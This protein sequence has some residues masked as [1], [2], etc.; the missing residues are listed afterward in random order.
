MSLIHLTWYCGAKFLAWLLTGGSPCCR[1]VTANR[2]CILPLQHLQP[3][4]SSLHL[5]TL[6][7][8]DFP[9]CPF[10]KS[11]LDS[12]CT[13]STSSSLSSTFLHPRKAAHL[14]LSSPTAYPLSL[15]LLWNCKAPCPP[16]PPPGHQQT[17]K[18]LAE[19]STQ[20]GP[21]GT[22][23]QGK[24]PVCPGGCHSRGAPAA[25]GCF[26]KAASDTLFLPAGLT[27]PLKVALLPWGERMAPWDTSAALGLRVS[28]SG[29]HSG[30][31]YLPGMASPLA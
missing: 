29:R 15:K 14:H 5:D 24:E 3:V 4:P 6:Q 19:H 28:A 31:A 23:G 17:R 12:Q 21:P 25:T 1:K 20:A 13:L 7:G 22:P 26:F 27:T 11:Y 30:D 9:S 8:N 16:H 10:S 2:L 18:W